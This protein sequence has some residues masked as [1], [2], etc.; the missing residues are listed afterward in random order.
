MPRS[1]MRQRAPER[2]TDQTGVSEVRG[3]LI[4][5]L[6]KRKGA[7]LFGDLY[8]GSAVFVNLQ[9]SFSPPKQG[10]L[11]LPR[12]HLKGLGFRV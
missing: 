5:V 6:M 11:K 9:A 2:R 8:V 4:G 10:A 12:N 3:Y 1:C 7:L